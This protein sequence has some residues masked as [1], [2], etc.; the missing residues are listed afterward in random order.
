MPVRRPMASQ[1]PPKKMAACMAT[2]STTP[3][4]LPRIN[5][6]RG[7][8]GSDVGSQNLVAGVALPVVA[9]E[10][11]QLVLLDRPAQRAAEL[12]EVVRALA[13]A[14]ALVGE[15][16]GV[17][18]LVAVELESRAV[19]GIGS[20]FG[21]H[22]DGPAAR[23][24]NLRGVTHGG[25]LKLLYRVFTEG[26]GTQ[27]GTASGLSEEQIVAVRAIHQQRTEGGG[28]E[29]RPE[30]APAAPPARVERDEREA[31]RQREET[32]RLAKAAA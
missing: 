14:A 24:A 2:N 11:E 26:I 19:E 3:K 5:S 9:A 4:Y 17:Q 7:A 27:S 20:R 25:H 31:Q 30:G 32:Q 23:A 13:R 8:G 22:V 29:I 1:V 10:E 6:Q 21:H 16:V 18:A 28:G 15:G 12:I